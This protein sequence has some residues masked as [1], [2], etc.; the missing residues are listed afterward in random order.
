[1]GT[2]AL[3]WLALSEAEGSS[4]AR[5]RRVPHFSRPLREVGL[6]TFDA[7]AAP[8]PATFEG[9][10]PHPRSKYKAPTGPCGPW[11]LKS[12]TF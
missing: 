6:L 12:D 5:L 3:G 9:W 2:A 10:E 11:R 4:K 1:V 7:T 8:S